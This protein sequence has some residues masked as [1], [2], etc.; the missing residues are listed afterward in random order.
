MISAV[1]TGVYAYMDATLLKTFFSGDS[2]IS[3]KKFF[4]RRDSMF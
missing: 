1:R 2:E 4:N 3:G